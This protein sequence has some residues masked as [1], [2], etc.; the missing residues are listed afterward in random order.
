MLNFAYE[1]D[2]KIENKYNAGISRT[3]TIYLAT[4]TICRPP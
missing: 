4:E 3:G 2:I 1:G